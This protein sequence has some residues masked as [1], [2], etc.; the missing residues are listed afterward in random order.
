MAILPGYALFVISQWWSVVL[1]L[2]STFWY[3]RQLA[4]YADHWLVQLAEIADL[5]AL[6]QGC[7][8]FHASSGRGTPVTHAVPRLVRALLIKYLEA[9][10]LRQTEELIDNHLLVKWFVGYELF[11][12]PPDHSTLS[13]FEQ[14]VFS[15][16]PRL[17]FDEVLRL[18]DQ[19]CPE[20]RERLQIVDTF[21]MHARAAKTYLIELIRALCQKLLT[22]LAEV[23][24]ARHTALVA[25]VDLIALFGAEGERITAA[26]SARG[27]AERL[28]VVGRQALRL[29]RLLAAS[30]DQA[31]TLVPDAQAPLRL[32]LAALAKVIAD[33]TTCTSPNPDDPDEIILVERKHGQKGSYRLGSATD[34]DPTYRKHD[35]EHEALLGYNPIVLSTVVFHREIQ[36][37]TGAQ[38]DNVA[39]P[40][41]LQ[42]QFD[43]HGFF[44]K[45][46][47]GDMKFGYGKTRALVADLT[48][49]QTQIIAFVPDY[50]RRTDLFGPRDFTLA[51]DGLSLTCPNGQ[52][53]DRRYLTEG[54]GG[55]DFRFPPSLCHDCPLWNQC[56]GPDS[57]KTVPRGVFI[58]FYRSHIDAALIFN[59]TDTFKLGIKQR[60]NIERHIFV[61]THFFGARHAQSYGLP[62]TDFQ[63][64][65]QAAAANLRQLVREVLKK[66]STQAPLR[67]LAA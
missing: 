40:E 48:A 65:M 64:K 37:V 34:L 58:S 21:G 26:L 32:W 67:P 54:K 16:Q 5:T 23:D 66:R 50:D 61:L 2:V 6:E 35:D 62:R 59:Q 38:P 42:S 24:P 15:H 46:L 25:Q 31:P 44:P 4:R 28:Q 43:H 11:E 49:D 33:E 30:L 51:D 10:S 20:D 29:G 63:L 19:L 7:A 57:K 47:A 22:H 9:R 55:A 41:V 53:T 27:R 12:R 1:Q 18:I 14:W 8:T 36:A 60:M 45:Y 3:E 17:F 13:R 52:T 56:R 39:L